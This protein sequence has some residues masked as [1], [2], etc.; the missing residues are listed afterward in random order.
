[1][2]RI[3]DRKELARMGGNPNTPLAIAMKE[4]VTV[5]NSETTKTFREQNPPFKSTHGYD[6]AYQSML[7]TFVAKGPGIKHQ[8]IEDMKL[9]DIAPFIA[10]LLGLD[11]IAP[12]GKLI[13]I[14]AD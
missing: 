10:E 9:V 5:S 13:Q 3:L 4:G 11:F 8:N 2:F 14:K 1:M 7:T 12:D 6:P